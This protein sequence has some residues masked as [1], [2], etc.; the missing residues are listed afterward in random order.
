ML[1]QD[2]P[3]NFYFQDPANP[4]MYGILELHDT[5]MFYMIILQVQ[6]LWI[7]ISLFFNKDH[8]FSL[9]HGNVIEVIWT[10][11][12]A[13][14]LWS[15]G[16]PSLTL[17]YMIDE[18][19]DAQ[20]TIKVIGNQWYWSYEY[21]DYTETLAF[22]SFLIPEED[23]E[24]GDLRNLAVD[25][26]LTLPVNTSI[27]FLVTSNDV[28]HSFAVPSLGLKCDAVPGRLNATGA[29]MTR[30]SIYYGQCSELCGILHGFMPIGIKAVSLPEYFT[31]ISTQLS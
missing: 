8:L 14:I 16:L 22:D 15:I 17:L 24:L 5:V 12:P 19:L 18:I 29:I 30:P 3:S 20:I 9:A 11:S 26:Y 21:S 31:Y 7:F 28:I 6:V 2:Y 10:L 23:Q 4:L 25:N 27:R 1:Y 13:L